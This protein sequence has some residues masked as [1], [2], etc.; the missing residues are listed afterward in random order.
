[1]LFQSKEGE[2]LEGTVNS[3]SKFG[4]LFV[5]GLT[6]DVLAPTRLL[7]KDLKD[8]SNGE[9]VDLIVTGVVGKR[10]TVST[11]S[12]EEIDVQPAA[13]PSWFDGHAEPS[14]FQY[15]IRNEGLS[16]GDACQDVGDQGDG[17]GEASDGEP[18]PEA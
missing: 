10:V 6:N 4:V 9:V 14:P 13:D 11:K 2:A 15:E 12:A 16:T 7:S 17:V 1:M 3:M 5:A 18:H 8:C